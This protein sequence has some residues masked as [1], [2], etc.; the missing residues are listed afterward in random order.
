MTQDADGSAPMLG[1]VANGWIP[2]ENSLPETFI[3][4]L[5]WCASPASRKCKYCEVA[6]RGMAGDWQHSH[7]FDKPTHWMPLPAP[8]SDGK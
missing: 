8:P 7:R 1:S 6:H 4:V 5:V 2:V 3:P